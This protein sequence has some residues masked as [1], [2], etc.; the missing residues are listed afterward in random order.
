MFDSVIRIFFR[1]LTWMFFIGMAVC[2]FTVVPMTPYKLFK[3]LF[4]KDRP[5]D[6]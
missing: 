1:A 3:V 6:Q 4:E 5:D 2:A